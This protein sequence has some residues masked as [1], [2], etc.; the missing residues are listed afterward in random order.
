MT[1]RGDPSPLL[2]H[3]ATALGIAASMSIALVL[4]AVLVASLVYSSLF[5]W[6]LHRFV[7]HRPVGP[8]TYPYRSHAITH[9]GVFTSAKDYHIQQGVDPHLVTMAW[10]NGPVLLLINVPTGLAA[11]KITGS[12]G[13]TA[14]FMGVMASYYIAYEYFHWCMHVPGP[15]WFQGTR[16]FK[17]VDRHHRLHHLEPMRNLNVVLPIADYLLGTRL[18]RAPQTEPQPQA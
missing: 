6:A 16:L 9:H 18:A 11:W 17:W 1:A 3:A 10:W 4:L 5:E 14:V 13:A 7:M 2:L 15:R 8:F 12:W